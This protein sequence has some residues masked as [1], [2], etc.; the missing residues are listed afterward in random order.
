M[1]IG[2]AD[3]AIGEFERVQAVAD[4]GSPYYQ[5]AAQLIDYVQQQMGR[6]AEGGAPSS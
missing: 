5:Q 1:N 2:R 6:A 4:E 3:Q